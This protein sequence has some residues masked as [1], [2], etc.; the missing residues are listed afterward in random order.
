MRG[1]SNGDETA[2]VK[3]HE[4]WG[5]ARNNRPDELFQLFEPQGG[6][7][8]AGQRRGMIVGKRRVLDRDNKWMSHWDGVPVTC[9]SLIGTSLP[10]FLTPLLLY[11]LYNHTF[12]RMEDDFSWNTSTV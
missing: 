6:I 12:S 5:G 9:C 4:S 7:Q 11:H 10:E 1:I 8:P 2:P 3:G